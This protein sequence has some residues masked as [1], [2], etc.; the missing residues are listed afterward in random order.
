MPSL[1]RN[2]QDIPQNLRYTL[3]QRVKHADLSI[4]LCE[5]NFPCRSV[6]IERWF[7]STLQSL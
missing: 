1:S 6:G 5:V 4:L 3:R 7:S 2:V